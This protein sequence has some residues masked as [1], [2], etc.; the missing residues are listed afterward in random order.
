MTDQEIVEL[1]D[2]SIA[3]EFELDEA[4]MKPEASLFGGKIPDPTTSVMT[5]GAHLL[6][7]GIGL[8]PW[9]C[10]ATER[11]IAPTILLHTDLRCL[12]T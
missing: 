9:T 4:D 7:R 8:W 3:E 12:A 5:Y 2:T 11:A 10:V 1:I 6:Q